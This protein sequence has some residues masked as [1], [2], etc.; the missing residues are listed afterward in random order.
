MFYFAK[1]EGKVV[2]GE[3]GP[4]GLLS[5][6]AIFREVCPGRGLGPQ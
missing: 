2:R 5:R 3:V 4:R 6:L 1:K